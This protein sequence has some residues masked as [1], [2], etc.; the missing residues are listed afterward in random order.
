LLLIFFPCSPL[1]KSII[2]TF[3]LIFHSSRILTPYIALIST[4]LFVFRSNNTTTISSNVMLSLRH[5]F[6]KEILAT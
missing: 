2:C 4:A 6:L 3:V 1:N 5:P